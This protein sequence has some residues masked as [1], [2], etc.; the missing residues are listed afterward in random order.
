MKYIK[1]ETAIQVAS[2]SEKS[3]W[4]LLINK[5]RFTIAVCLQSGI[6]T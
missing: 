5:V 6:E 1:T 3:Q 4:L 2:E